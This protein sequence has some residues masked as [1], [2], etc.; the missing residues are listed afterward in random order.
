VIGDSLFCAIV[1]GVAATLTFFL[2]PLVRLVSVRSGILDAPS[3]A[4]KTHASPTP[5]FGGVAIWGGF[6]GAMALLRLTTNFPSGTLFNLRSL[7]F[8]GTMMFGLGLADDLRRPHGL[9]YKP[10]F[11]VQFAATAMLVVYGLRIR[12]IH[13]DWVSVAVTL[14]WVVGVTNALNIIDIMDGLAATQAAVAA[15]GF[16]FVSLPSEEHYVKFAAAAI[17][18]AA[19]GFL[20][21][22]LSK[23]HKVFMGDCG[24]LLLGFLLAGVS[25]GA[26]Y[27]GVNDAGV[28]APVLILGVPIFDTL[29]VSLL[30]LNQGKSPFLG[31]KDHFALRLER[32]GLS[33]REVVLVA[34][35]AA[36]ALGV[37]AFLATQHSLK[38]ALEL[39][40]L[41]AAAVLVVG[42]RLAAVSMK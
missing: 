1:F 27:S 9:D 21:W 24:A 20:P 31:S 8:G 30:R 4:I 22:N 7:V 5:V 32:M 12:F 40:A 35:A 18:G 16:L 33:R 41:V 11:L 14:V 6:V 38:R 29:F 39:Y 13:P 19:L 37:G 26:H 34:A 42:R 3:S 2:T 23:R 10:K 15:L 25:L 36:G 17:A 28:F